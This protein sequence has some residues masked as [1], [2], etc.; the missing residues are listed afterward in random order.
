MLPCRG[1]KMAGGLGFEPR[2]TESE[3][4]VLPLDDPQSHG[5]RS[6]ARAVF[7]VNRHRRMTSPQGLGGLAFLGFALY[8]GQWIRVWHTRFGSWRATICVPVGFARGWRIISLFCFSARLPAY[9]DAPRR[10]IATVKL[11]AGKY[12]RPCY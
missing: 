8:N 3:S 9:I 10:R 7:F 2:L 12:E 6:V 5:R 4:V 1:S 11:C